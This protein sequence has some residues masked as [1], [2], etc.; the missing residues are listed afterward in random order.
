MKAS[1]LSLRAHLCTD[2][3]CLGLYPSWLR[4]RGEKDLVGEKGKHGLVRI[5]PIPP[6]EFS[7]SSMFCSSRSVF[8]SPAAL[9]QLQ[10]RPQLAWLSSLFPHCPFWRSPWKSRP[11][12]GAES[13][14]LTVF[15]AGARGFIQLSSRPVRKCG[16]KSDFVALLTVALSPYGTML[17]HNPF[18]ILGLAYP[19]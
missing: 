13:E 18:A 14:L 16:C 5:S 2:S 10:T 7:G 6:R 1:A 8:S 4:R 3:S 17:W 12:G 15:T 19:N 11:S 9:C